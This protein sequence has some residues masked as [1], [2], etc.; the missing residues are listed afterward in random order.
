MAL[1]STRRRGRSISPSRSGS[2]FTGQA[3]PQPCWSIAPMLRSIR[4]RTGAEIWRLS[5]LRP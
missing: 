1:S 4:Q 5:P 2:P 3:R